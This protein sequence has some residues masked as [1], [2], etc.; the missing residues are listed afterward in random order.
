[1]PNQKLKPFFFQFSDLESFYDAIDKDPMITALY[2]FSEDCI[3]SSV[4]WDEWL[5]LWRQIGFNYLIIKRFKGR[6]L[7]KRDQLRRDLAIYR[8]YKMDVPFKLLSAVTGFTPYY[9]RKKVGKVFGILCSADNQCPFH[10]Y[11]KK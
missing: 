5:K 9:L 7:S 6:K 4:N 8:L 3:D 2:D 11:F 1:M 10:S